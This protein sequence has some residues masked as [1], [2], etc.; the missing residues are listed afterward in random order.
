MHTHGRQV[1]QWYSFSRLVTG[2]IILPL[3]SDY[4]FGFLNLSI[5]LDYVFGIYLKGHI[6]IKSFFLA[7]STFL[8]MCICVQVCV[9]THILTLLG[10]HLQ[11]FFS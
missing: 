9:H 4:A 5:F 1:G 6:L 2:T 7:F 10:Y 3:L 8:C 11:L